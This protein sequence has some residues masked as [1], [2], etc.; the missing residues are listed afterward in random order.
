MAA[1]LAGLDLEMPFQMVLAGCLEPAV[2]QG[3]LPLARVDEAVL[4]QLLLQLRLPAGDYPVSLRGCPAH[5]ALALQ[6]ARESIVLLRNEGAVLP[7]SG[8]GSLAVL[9]RLADEPNLGDRGSSD[10]RPSPGCVV[11][12]LQGLRQAA[13]ELAIAFDR[14]GEATTAAALAARCDAAVV[15]VGLD[16]RLEG[17]HI[18]PADIAPILAMMPPPLWLRLRQ[19]CRP[20]DRHAWLA[21]DR[22]R[23]APAC[24]TS[25]PPR[26][27]RTGHPGR[28]APSQTRKIGRA[29]V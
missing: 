14:G 24:R 2:Q 18:H 13:P 29:H 28:R 27:A 5:R 26:S 12:P 17:E 10:T 7:F 6:A 23:A 25:W 21:R 15:V 20:T 1:V 16:W 4:R 3:R 19:S 11:T 8:L 22:E 9:G